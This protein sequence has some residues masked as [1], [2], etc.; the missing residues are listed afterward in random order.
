MPYTTARGSVK[1]NHYNYCYDVYSGIRWLLRLGIVWPH[2]LLVSLSSPTSGIS[3]TSPDRKWMMSLAQVSENTHQI[4]CM[5]WARIQYDLFKKTIWKTK[6]LSW[7]VCPLHNEEPQGMIIW[8]HVHL[9]WK[10][11][12]VQLPWQ[13]CSALLAAHQSCPCHLV[14]HGAR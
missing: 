10:E 9:S 7:K 11:S 1:P 6:L 3:L 14:F 4:S 13:W 8:C 5:Q 2:S 12:E